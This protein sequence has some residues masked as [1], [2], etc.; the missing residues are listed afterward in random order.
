MVDNNNDINLILN[1][2]FHEYDFPIAYGTFTKADHMLIEKETI[3]QIEMMQS[4]LSNHK[5]IKLKIH[6]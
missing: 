1:P 4:V 3:S 5:V 2:S 6:L